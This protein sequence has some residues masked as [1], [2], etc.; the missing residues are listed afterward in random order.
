MVDWDYLAYVS[1]YLLINLSTYLYF[2][3]C[4]GT[5][6]LNSRDRFGYLAENEAA[7]KRY[8][9]KRR[10]PCKD[11]VGEWGDDPEVR[12]SLSPPLS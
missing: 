1:I 2:E 6:L 7:F 11:G 10:R 12:L 8:V 3:L 9:E 4:D 5:G